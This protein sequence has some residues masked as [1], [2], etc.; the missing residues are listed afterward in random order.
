MFARVGDVRLF[1]KSEVTFVHAGISTVLFIPKY[2]LHRSAVRLV[3]DSD[4]KIREG[5]STTMAA[6]ANASRQVFR[7]FIT[8]TM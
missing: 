4:P 8:C 3:D 6:I 2:V 1:F 7:F 5:G